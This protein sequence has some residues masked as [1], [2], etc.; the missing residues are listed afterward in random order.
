MSNRMYCI[1]LYCY[2][3]VIFTDVGVTLNFGTNNV[4]R[5]GGVSYSIL[6]C[7]C[8]CVLFVFMSVLLIHQYRIVN[9]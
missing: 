3:K 5:D 2:N 4:N 6:Y 8:M 1:V 9:M 7:V